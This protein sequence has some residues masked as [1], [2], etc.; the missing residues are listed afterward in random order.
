MIFLMMIFEHKYQLKY[1]HEKSEEK[2][3]PIEYGRSKNENKMRA[4]HFVLT[5]TF[6]F[7]FMC[8]AHG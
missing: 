4:M 8:T 1:I 6:P 2:T 3:K 5:P 7:Q